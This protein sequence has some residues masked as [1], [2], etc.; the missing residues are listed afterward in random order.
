MNCKPTPCIQM[1]G[2]LN[3]P[4]KC[5]IFFIAIIAVALEVVFH[6]YH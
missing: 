5:D 3:F 1:T 2:G 4:V 6:K